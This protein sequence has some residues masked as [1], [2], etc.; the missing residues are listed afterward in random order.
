MGFKEN[1]VH[2]VKHLGR[3]VSEKSPT[4]LIIGG[5]VGLLAAGVV[6]AVETHKK[7]DG[8][9]TEHKEKVQALKDIR[10]GVVVLDEYTTED[11]AQNYYKKHLTHVYLSTVCKLFRAYAPALILA[12]LSLTGILTG[13]KILSARHLAAVAEAYTANET[14]NQYRKRVAGAIGE[15]KEKLLFLDADKQL[16]TDNVMDPE[17]GEIKTSSHEGLVGNEHKM[18]YTYIIEPDNCNSWLYGISDA[19]TRGAVARLVQN[20]NRYLESH[21][22]VILG[23][24]MRHS[25]HDDY[26]RDNDEVFRAGWWLDN[27][28]VT[29]PD[30]IAQVSADVVLVSGPNEP[31]RYAVTFNCQGDILSAMSKANKDKKEARKQERKERAKARVRASVRQPAY[32]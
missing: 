26:L 2:G 29:N 9:I 1:L 16:I 5:A 31:R 20:A 23:E 15:E 7:L 27:P 10:D 11:Y 32:A 21:S 24:V 4:L 12:A 28:Y 3:K 25:W 30:G 17:T 19:S 22:Y 18:S 13:H 8:I 6:A 14:L